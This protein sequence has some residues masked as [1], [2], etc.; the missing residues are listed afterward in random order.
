[1]LTLT[2]GLSFLLRSSPILS[3]PFLT[4]ALLARLGLP[5]WLSLSVGLLT[6]PALVAFL[7][8][9]RDW[10]NQRAATALG[11]RLIPVVRGRSIA[12]I[13][14]LKQ[15]RYNRKY[16]YP[17]D[18]LREAIDELGPT[19]NFRVLWMATNLTTAPEHIK[20]ILA[21]DF[22]NYVKGERF[23]YGMRGVL[24]TGVFNSDGDMWKFHRQITRPFF[25]RDRI[26]H[27][28]LFDRH[29]DDVVSLLK[30]RT[31]EGY[32]V[33]FQDLIGRFTM[34][35]AS[36]FLFDSCIHSLK[37]HIPY[38]HNIPASSLPPPPSD[39]TALAAT[40]F[41]D[42][43]TEAMLRISEREVLGR[44]WP[45]F[46]IM[47]DKT[48]PAMKVISE[49]LDP[50]IAAAVEKKRLGKVQDQT[51]EDRDGMS[52]L[53]EMLEQT[54]DP[55]VLKDEMLNMLLA[56]R[57]TTMHTL[58]VCV[59]FFT[60]YPDIY[61][62]AREEM[63]AQVGPTRRP[64]YEDIKEMK[65]LR[66]VLNETMRLY[67]SVPFNIRE[68]VEATTWP[69]PDP[70]DPRP[71]YVPAGSKLAY[72]VFIMHRRKDLW[73][74]DAEEFDPDRFLDDRVKNTILKNTFQFLP[75]NAGPRI[76]LGQQ[77]AY[78]EMAFM[79]VRFMQAF[80]AVAL[81]ESAFAPGALPPDVWKSCAGRKGMER[82]RPKLHMT[83]STQ[84]GLWIN[85]TEAT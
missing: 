10:R 29:A 82:F 44:I 28:D 51:E 9:R 22:N 77:F 12:S 57:D 46:E 61:R 66:A 84:D 55:Q 2:P 85:V 37:A 26:S 27:F 18:G 81:D 38:P 64:T 20:L 16:G 1:M 50:V 58:T 23:R 53:T 69:S 32:S 74:A 25:S 30:R 45:L 59:Y 43:F 11:A 24:G 49:Y 42:A 62:R 5:R 3:L 14:I 63:L 13:D 78:N 4:G 40:R 72:S 8:V 79:L 67:P 68:N 41:T 33:D 31:R 60:M 56:G 80:A 36:E 70:A 75:F 54:D 39:P 83:M 15:M 52:L 35:S 71:L 65:F 21:T 6:L 47:G 76:C 7:V 19:V 48:K 73:G 34:D 17:A